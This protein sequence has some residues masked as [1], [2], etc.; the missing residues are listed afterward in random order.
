MEK[1]PNNFSQWFPKLEEGKF[2]IEKA[3][4][5]LPKSW[6]FDVP[7]IVQKSWY[8]Y[9]IGMT[10]E[11]FNKYISDFVDSISFVFDEQPVLF[12][13]N[14]TFSDKFNFDRCLSTR[15][16]IKSHLMDINYK[17][18]VVGAGGIDEVVFREVIQ[19]NPTITPTIY[20]GL[21]FRPEF[22]VFYDFDVNRVLYICNYWDNDYCY[23]SISR[24]AT[25]KIVWDAYHDYVDKMYEKY[26]QEIV[27][28]VDLAM[29]GVNMSG[30]W[31]I[32][33]LLDE[34]NNYWLIDMAKAENSAYWN[35]ELVK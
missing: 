2:A 24:N 14:G 13:K 5:K 18:L 10:Y 4:L 16:T 31:S 35:P 7:E 34:W 32:D 33:V 21:P 27:N 6:W 9:D 11:E 23:E 8:A 19:S 15:D 12:N 22:R 29:L 17:A 3:G 30:I 25:D 26:K 20:H 28:K 1:N